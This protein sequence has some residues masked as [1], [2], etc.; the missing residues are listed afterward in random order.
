MATRRGS[1][2]RPANQQGS[3]QQPSGQQPAGQQHSASQQ[4]YERAYRSYVNQ[5]RAAQGGR[6]G[7]PANRAGYQQAP[8]QQTAYQ[9]PVGN[10]QQGY[11]QYGNGSYMQQVPNGWQPVQKKKGHPVRNTLIV[12]LLLL[13]VIG[14]VGGFTGYNLYQSAKTVKADA[15][16]VMTDIS[17]LKSQLLSDNPSQAN[18]TAADIAKRAQNMKKETSGWEWTVASYVPVYGGDVAKVKELSDVLDELAQDAVVPLVGEV[19]Q[20]SLKNLFVDGGINVEYA[21]Q[22]VGAVASAAPVIDKCTTKIEAMGEAKL[23]QVNEPLKKAKDALGKLNTAAQFVDGIA[24]TFADMIGAD[25]KPRTYLLCA[26]QLS[27]VRSTG[28]LI[29]SVGAMTIDNG[30]L[31]LNEFRPVGD[32]YPELGAPHFETTEEETNLFGSNAS[33]VPSTTNYI[34][35]WARVSQIIAYYWEQRGY[36]GV[37]GV[38]GIDPVFLQHILALTG[39]VTTPSG[40][41]VDGSNAAQLIGHDVY[42]IPE[43]PT[44][45]PQDM[46][47]TEIGSSVFNHLIANIGNVPMMALAQQLHK[48]MVAR[49]LQV[50]MYNENEEAAMALLGCDGTL[51]TDP[52]KPTLGVYTNDD[53]WSKLCWYLKITN[54]V[55]EGVHNADGTTTYHVVSRLSNMIKPGNEDELSESMIAHNVKEVRSPSDMMQWV[56]LSAPAGGS[57]T[58]LST[59]GYF[60]TDMHE[61]TYRGIQF[62]NGHAQFDSGE[63]ITLTYDVTVP[64]EAEEKLTV[65]TSPTY[66]VE[67]GW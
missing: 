22:M 64:K 7:Q 33:W 57:I 17:D 1:H 62:F 10:R 15:A 46:L 11:A 16:V 29:G 42:Y 20:V 19:S 50:Y 3:Y 36:G 35:D 63:T 55:S 34:T 51:P 8:S 49:H 2:Q 41:T 32:I 59:D 52:T 47:F 61:S 40:V 5:Q 25:G 24:P 67:A 58:N 48:D 30:R 66:Q 21:K 39:P 26:Q 65:I 38:I 12:I 18:A 54:D 6:Y 23:D 45:K 14:G 4:A 9:Q 37:D 44:Y 31:S 28:G 60:T 56:Y 27:E 13:L 53:S 43:T